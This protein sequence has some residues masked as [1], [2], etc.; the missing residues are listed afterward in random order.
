MLK[1]ILFCAWTLAGLS[2]VGAAP[3]G[4][5]ENGAYVVTVDS[6]DATLGAEDV[7]ALGTSVTLVKR[8]AGR[9]VIA[10]DLAGWTGELRVEAG[11]LRAQHT[12]AMGYAAASATSGGVVVKA[13]GTLELDGSVMQ[14]GANKPYAACGRY[15]LE[16]SGVDGT[17]GA[18]RL[19]NASS[20]WAGSNIAILLT[21][22]TTFTADRPE[23]QLDIR[24]TARYDMGGH[25]VTIDGMRLCIC[26]GPAVQRAGDFVVKN[27]GHF[28]SEQTNFGADAKDRKIAFEDG[29]GFRVT[30]IKDGHN[31][32]NL[33]FAGRSTWYTQNWSDDIFNPNN[34]LNGPVDLGGTATIQFQE[35]NT[36]AE[37]NT[38]E[39]KGKVSGAGGFA[40]NDG[41]LLLSNPS[42]DFSGLTTVSGKH[43]HIIAKDWYA[44][45]SAT[46]GN[47]RVA[48]NATVEIRLDPTNHPPSAKIDGE[49]AGYFR[50][51]ASSV[52]GGS[53]ALD[54]LGTYTYTT[55][56]AE[57]FGPIDHAGGTLVFENC[58][59]LWQGGQ[60]NYLAAPWPGVARMGVGAGAAFGNAVA[61]PVADAAN[62]KINDMRFMVL[63]RT[64]T[65]NADNMRAI[66]EVADGGVVTNRLHVAGGVWNG[67]TVSAKAAGAVFIRNGGRVYNPYVSDASGYVGNVGHGYVEV[68]DGGAW[69]MGG[70]WVRFGSYSGYGVYWQKGGDVTHGGQ[71]ITPGFSGGHG[72]MRVSGGTL[73]SKRGLMLNCTLWGKDD[74]AGDSVV[75]IDGGKMT[76][77]DLCVMA[78]NSGSTAILNL[79]GGVFRPMA[80]DKATNVWNS[81][82]CNYVAVTN[83]YGPAGLPYSGNRA[84]VNFNGGTLRGY[85]DE[86]CLFGSR[87][88]RMSKPDRATV[89][90]GG[91]V[92]DT[93]GKRVT[94]NLPLRAPSGKGIAQ[95]PFS[96]ATPWNYTGSP[97]VTIVGDGTGASAFA[98]FDSTNGTVTGVVVTS[99][100]NDYTTAKAVIARGGWTNTVEI[101]LTPHL[102]DNAL[103]GGLTKI[104]AGCLDLSA[105]NTYRGP[106]VVCEGTLRLGVD[107]AID[108]A[109]LLRVEAG[110]T[111]DLN[112]KALAVS[113]LAG[114]GTVVGDL[115]V[116]GIWRVD[117]AD[118]L[119]G[120]VL[121]VDGAVTLAPETTIHVDDPTGLLQAQDNRRTFQLIRATAISGHAVIEIDNLDP[122]WVARVN[123]AA[124]QL[125]YRRGTLII[126]H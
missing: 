10:C 43:A 32:F 11:Y 119:A 34:V 44:L 95:V 114:G 62:K 80:I 91:A 5:L 83:A 99:P 35:A 102:A 54:I 76:L 87:D 57:T 14:A 68:E 79:N 117:A 118:L 25:A 51:R 124:V 105:V 55:P 23:R 110:A 27:G 33:A 58:G 40:V 72:R 3:L 1:K 120:R 8:G 96:C 49:L 81:L 67:G 64:A 65:R 82:S 107:N 7:S 38:V 100:G 125:G 13:G 6:G 21:G 103:T 109:S 28:S 61:T 123:G 66:L 111:A 116:S 36:K 121:T 63:G 24:Y 16:G 19:I 101:P 70:E 86:A 17:A 52:Q 73:A 48:N 26:N 47:L 98:V 84:D 90:A 12:G 89:Y 15:L 9:L 22:D 74:T 69:H 41:W 2:P 20:Y 115:T 112:G 88:G 37:H 60:T 122:P 126:F 4:A 42:N 45:P 93:A 31:H 29:T 108:A 77:E 75:T 113:G 59:M 71:N 56:T 94:L 106:T 50:N 97:A 46:N 78:A 85:Y 30:R 39:L 53:L 18:V 104:G 92:I